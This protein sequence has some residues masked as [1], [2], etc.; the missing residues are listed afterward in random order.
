LIFL[1]GKLVCKWQDTAGQEK[2]NS[3]TPLYYRDT[4]GAILVYDITFKESFEK[5]AK[6]ITE[7]QSFCENDVVIAITGNKGDRE[8]ERQIR[9]KDAENYAKIVD[10]E[11]FSTSA[12]SGKGINDIFDYVAKSKDTPKEFLNGFWWMKKGSAGNSH[13]WKGAFE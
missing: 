9:L 2:F 6:W 1:Y 13:S 8:N 5:V 7:L 4:Q 12:K 11:H 3:L 10:A